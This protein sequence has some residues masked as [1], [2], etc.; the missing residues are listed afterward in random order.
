MAIDRTDIAR[1]RRILI[2]Q[3]TAY[4]PNSEIVDQFWTEGEDHGPLPVEKASPDG[5]RLTLV[6][7]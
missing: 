3:Q 4:Q 7:G 5:R 2:E 6:H 1:I